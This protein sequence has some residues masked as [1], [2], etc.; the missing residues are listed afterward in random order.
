MKKFLSL[1][2]SCFL[3]LSSIAHAELMVN[4]LDGFD[5]GGGLGPVSSTFI[6][7]TDI[8]TANTI[9]TYTAHAVGTADPNRTTLVMVYGDDATVFGVSTV[10]V[11]GDSATEVVDQEGAGSLVD[12]AIYVLANPVGTAE[13]IVVTWSEAIARSSVC[14]YSVL[15]LISLTPVATTTDFET[16]S[17]QG[18]LS[19]ST[20]AGGIAFLA[21]VNRNNDG[22]N[23]L[24][25]V[26][27]DSTVLSNGTWTYD[28]A[29][30]LTS[31]TEAPRTITSD[32]G[33]GGD[34]SFVS[35]SFR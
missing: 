12:V 25:G 22:T 32:W 21:T 5:V 20:T 11:N 15:N 16:S 2:C 8:T 29:S 24:V 13:D 10:T 9:Y 31:T 18:T 17:A 7:C 19:I 3:F 34:A 27:S 14:V 26:T 35:A 4:Q 33:G 1:L 23:T 30:A 28:A 6:G